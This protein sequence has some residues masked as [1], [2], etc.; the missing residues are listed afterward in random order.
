MEDN[1]F[2]ILWWVLPCMCLLHPEAHFLLP[3][4]PIP[5]GCYRGPDLGAPFPTLN[6]HWHVVLYMFQCYSFKLPHPL[7]SLTSLVGQTVKRLPTMRETWVRF[8]GQEDLL[9]KEMATH[10]STLAWKIPSTEE[11]GRLQSMRS[12]R[13]RYDWEASLTPLTESKSPFFKP[14]SPL[15]PV[16]RIISSIFGNSIYL[17]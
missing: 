4:H 14:V 12:Q 3:P 17:Y 1:Y 10:S 5:L 2:T 9:E 13:V 15:Q 16:Y 11:P 6:S 7:L 8:L